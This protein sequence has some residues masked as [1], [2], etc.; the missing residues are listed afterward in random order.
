MRIDNLVIELTRR[1][2]LKCKHCLRG[3]AQSIDINPDLVA[4]FIQKNHI[5][6]ISSLV[7]TGGEPCL[8]ASSMGVIARDLVRL[9]VHIGT[10]FM[11]TNGLVFQL[12]MMNA[13]GLLHSICDETE[14]FTL[15]ISRDKYHDNK[16]IHPSWG[17]LKTAE[18]PIGS[19]L[20]EGR[21]A[22]LPPDKYSHKPKVDSWYWS[23]D[24]DGGVLLREG[25]VYINA[26]GNIVKC[27]DFSY[28]HQDKETLGHCL[29]KT[30]IEYDSEGYEAAEEN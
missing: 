2:N 9:K 16:K 19:L 22:K 4:K 24:G 8:A 5:D 28:A 6:Y 14:L 21:G 18:H 15:A 27:C 1:C 20:L 11:A 29:A 25:M 3:P 12:E 10:F 13:L 23:K 30:L 26:K 17:L 7:F